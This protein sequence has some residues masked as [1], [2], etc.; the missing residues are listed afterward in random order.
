M[1]KMKKITA[2]LLASALLILPTCASAANLNGVVANKWE[3]NGTIQNAVLTDEGHILA[4]NSYDFALLS[5]DNGE[6]LSKGRNRPSFPTKGMVKMADGNIFIAGSQG[7]WKVVDSYGD[8]ISQGKLSDSRN[9][10]FV[11]QLSNENILLVQDSGYY[12]IL[13]SSQE[14]LRTGKWQN[15]WHINDSVELP[16]GNL[17]MVGDQGKYQVMSQKD[18]KIVDSGDW[19]ATKHHIVSIDKLSDN[20]M[21]A[22]GAGSKFILFDKTGKKIDSAELSDQESKNYKWDKVVGLDNQHALVISSTGLILLVHV[23]D[24][25]HISIKAKTKISNYSSNGSVFKVA[26]N[27]VFVTL[28][29][30]RFIIYQADL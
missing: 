10:R 16:N 8:E 4:E 18:G 9:T 23:D 19:G 25:N 15:T 26:N 29:S 27:Q 20:R 14:L 3:A 21:L 2:S 6:T 1:I 7:K 30:G 12:T 5:T 22:V 13:N 28:S 24:K 17:L 11:K